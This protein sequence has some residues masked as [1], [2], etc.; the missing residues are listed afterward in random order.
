MVMVMVHHVAAGGKCFLA[1]RTCSAWRDLHPSTVFAS[2]MRGEPLD[3]TK[4]ATTLRARNE[5]GRFTGHVQSR[6]V[7][8]E[9]NQ[10]FI[11]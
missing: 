5:L 1:F 2:T 11:G 3:S 4:G 7:S 8:V 6:I 10:I 9:L